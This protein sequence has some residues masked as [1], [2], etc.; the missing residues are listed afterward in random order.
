MKFKY[1]RYYLYYW[2]R[3][4]AF[5]IYIVPLR[6]ALAIA[7]ICGYVA[8][9][10]AVKY[11]RIA[12]ENLK[13][14]FG[15]E[16]TETEIR[17]IA[18]GVF[19]NL[20]RNAVELINAP[21]LTCANLEKYIK[22]RNIER[23]SEALKNGK[24]ILMLTGHF[25]NWEVLA[26][27]FKIKGYHGA[28]IGRRI[29]FEKYDKFLNG[30]REYHGVKIIYRDDS[31]KAILR[32]LKQN[33]IMGILADQDVDSVEGVFVNFFGRPAYT[34]VGPV[35]LARA[36]GASLMPAFMIRRG[37][38]HE[39]V[40]EKPIELSTTDNKESD[41]IT[42]TQKWSDVVESYIRQ[43]PDHWV[44]MHRR[45]KTRKAL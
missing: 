10:A 21:K 38:S 30:L 19:K 35:A 3:L 9:W 41:A 4:F 11:R 39:L 12:I 23:V 14:A 8:F 40:V 34:P 13:Q 1:R 15:K 31:P 5:I 32:V 17:A 20:C 2:A 18:L 16:K 22:I 43:Y 29:Y 7:D 24:G 44:W 45:W 37:N 26:M 33:G 6:I 28:A 27:A 42:N 36:S 25:G